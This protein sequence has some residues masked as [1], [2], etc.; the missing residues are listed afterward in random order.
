MSSDAGSLL[1]CPACQ[2][3]RNICHI[4]KCQQGLSTFMLPGSEQHIP[5]LLKYLSG[6]RALKENPKCGG[7]KM[8]SRTSL[9][10]WE[11]IINDLCKSTKGFGSFFSESSC[12]GYVGHN[13]LFAHTATAVS[14]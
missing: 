2:V 12:A 10:L 11:N 5:A 9:F 3:V 13:Q 8:K 1:K 7:L 6:L 14:E 4:I